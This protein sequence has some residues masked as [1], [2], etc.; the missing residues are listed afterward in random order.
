MTATSEALARLKSLLQRDLDQR[1]QKVMTTLSDVA[2]SRVTLTLQTSEIKGSVSGVALGSQLPLY[3]DGNDRWS[4]NDAYPYVPLN[5][6]IPEKDVT[7]WV[8]YP[9]PYNE[10]TWPVELEV[11]QR[12]L[13]TPGLF[14]EIWNRWG[15]DS[16]RPFPTNILGQYEFVFDKRR[17][18]EWL[19]ANGISVSMM[20]HRNPKDV[21]S[22]DRKFEESFIH[23]VCLI[24]GHRYFL[25]TVED[26]NTLRKDISALESDAASGR[27]ASQ[28]LAT[29]DAEIVGRLRDTAYLIKAKHGKEA[30]DLAFEMQSHVRSFLLNRKRI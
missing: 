29:N 12:I 27:G 3:K 21:M 16:H 9:I 26:F 10:H 18:V 22:I 14:Q 28:P 2:V 24:E 30:G 15:S 17:E 6:Y 13:P 5:C 23:T 20:L 8:D 11:N 1:L 4:L 25:K 7:L 19:N